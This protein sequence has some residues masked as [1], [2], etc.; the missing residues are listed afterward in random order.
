MKL[1][2]N[3]KIFFWFNSKQG[4]S[5]FFDAMMLFCGKYLIFFILALSFILTFRFGALNYFSKFVLISLILGIASSYF[6]GWAWVRKRPV[7]DFPTIKELF[8]PFSNWKSFPSDHTIISFICVES[9]IYTGIDSLICILFALAALLVGISR[10]Y[11]GLHYPRDILG[12][13]VYATLAC[14]LS[15][16]IL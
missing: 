7:V 4:N 3:N 15:S 16:I 12:G 13:I 14:Y 8:G 1:S 6:T 10:I 2:L 9:L 5:K 11:A